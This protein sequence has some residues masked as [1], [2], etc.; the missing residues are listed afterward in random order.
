VIILIKKLSDSNS[1][2]LRFLGVGGAATLTHA[3]LYIGCLEFLTLDPQ[4]AN[5]LGFVFSFGIS[6]IG[7][8][9]WTFG[10]IQLK[11]EFT[12]KLKFFASSLVSLALNALWVR[13]TVEILELQPIFSVV[14]IVFFTPVVIFLILKFWVFT[15]NPK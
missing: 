5:I 8:R 4:T 7:Q 13:V 9:R 1:I 14:G 2:L 11:C 6:Y 15:H 12:A 10:H 3:F